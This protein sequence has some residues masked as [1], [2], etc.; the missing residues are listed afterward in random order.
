MR[1]LAQGRRGAE[2]DVDP[3]RAGIDGDPR[4]IHVAAHVGEHLGPKRQRRDR[5]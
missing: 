5:P 2:E 4:V 1:E 3:V